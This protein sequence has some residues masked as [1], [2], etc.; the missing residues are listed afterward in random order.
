MQ[1]VLNEH[2]FSSLSWLTW[3]EI[4]DHT[5]MLTSSIC[6]TSIKFSC[7]SGLTWLAIL[8]P[9]SMSTSSMSWS[10]MI[11]SCVSTSLT[12]RFFLNVVTCLTC[13][14]LYDSSH[15]TWLDLLFWRISF[16]LPVYPHFKKDLWW[17]VV[18]WNAIIWDHKK[19]PSRK[20]VGNFNFVF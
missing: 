11:G 14:G 19:C 10:S 8:D 15:L 1:H 17:G 16:F 5:N 7:V 2:D 4:L 18:T 13:L 3:L 6:W 9:T 12:W 20:Q